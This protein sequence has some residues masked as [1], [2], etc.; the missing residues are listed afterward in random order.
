[1]AIQ[2]QQRY[3]YYGA[4]LD[5]FILKNPGC[6]PTLIS[7]EDVER[8]QIY[9]I[10]TSEAKGEYILF[11]KY[12]TNCNSETENYRSWTFSFLDKDRDLLKKYNEKYPIFICLL[13]GQKPLN[14]SKIAIL[15]YEEFLKVTNKTSITI[16]L[17]KSSSTFLLFKGT[18]RERNKA[19]KFPTKRIEQKL[20][21]I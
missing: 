20:E 4:I 18:S 15:K 6:S 19:Y 8:R 5:T 7:K 12:T 10:L 11:F 3:F 16:G 1:M 2:M 9:K 14:K 13:C 21:S 17:K